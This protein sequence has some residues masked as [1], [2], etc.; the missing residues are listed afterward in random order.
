MFPIGALH[1]GLMVAIAFACVVLWNQIFASLSAGYPIVTYESRRPVPWGPR[2]VVLIVVGTI[3]IIR[4][5]AWP[6]TA[7]T[8]HESENVVATSEEAATAQD[9][10]ESQANPQDESS[11]KADQETEAPATE[12]TFAL[13]A[14]S[15]SGTFLAMLGAISWLRFRGA[16][17]ADLGLDGSRLSRD[18]QL[19]VAG[20][21][22]ASMP[23]YIIQYLAARYIPAH[24]PVTDIFQASPNPMMLLVTVVSAVVVAP[25]T[26]EFFFRVLLQGWLEARFA[27]RRNDAILTTSD[28]AM[29]EGLP[30][31]GGLVVPGEP[32]AP[33]SD[34]ESRFL[35]Q[36]IAVEQ[37]SVIPI[38][39]SSFIF[40]IV[41]LGYGPSALP[42]F[43]FALVLGYLYRQTHRVWPSLIAHA[44]LNALS[45]FI[46][47]TSPS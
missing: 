33:A 4:V 31:Q 27:E 2:D 28:E 3:L 42:L 21:V 22:V 29:V 1:L 20:F 38:L 44:S 45:T 5:C 37:P 12:R 25:M 15:A 10:R 6:L 41:H 26:E 7:L 46:M 11:A 32:A 14:A 30:D 40:A 23:I 19:G 8:H 36:P 9:A 34:S 35:A 17:L 24:H 39:L 13:V 18:F 47:I 43:F 16:S